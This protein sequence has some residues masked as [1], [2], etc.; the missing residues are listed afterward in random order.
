MTISE[1]VRTI[2]NKIKQN[3]D[4]YDLDNQK[5]RFWL[6]HQEMLANTNFCLAKMFYRKKT[7]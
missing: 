6:F 2:H 3:K 4:P 1:K 7:C 5:V